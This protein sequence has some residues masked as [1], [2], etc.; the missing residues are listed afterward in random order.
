MRFTD[1]NADPQILRRA[2]SPP[3]DYYL[4]ATLRSV[5]RTVAPLEW[6]DADL[7]ER[8]MTIRRSAW[9]GP[10]TLPKGGRER[11]LPLTKPLA[12]TSAEHLHLRSSRVLVQDDGTPLTRQIVQTRVKAAA[13]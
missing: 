10:V 1:R 2:A 5:Q 7:K 9:N 3:H 4:L 6:N 13:R 8:Q 11:H 12:T